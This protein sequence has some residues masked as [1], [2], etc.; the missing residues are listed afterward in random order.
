MNGPTEVKS[1]NIAWPAMGCAKAAAACRTSATNRAVV[2]FKGYNRRTNAAFHA[3][4]H[5][6]PRSKESSR[7]TIHRFVCCASTHDEEC[8]VLD[9]PRTSL[10]A[11]VRAGRRCV[12]GNCRRPQGGP[13]PKSD[14]VGGSCRS[15]RRPLMNIEDM[16]PFAATQE[17][18]WTLSADRKSVR[19]AV[20]ARSWLTPRWRPQQ[21]GQCR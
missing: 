12:Q 3:P 7:S 14:R 2:G 21:P 16:M 5:T 11:N 18:M 6:A 4:W 10:P 19:L 8:A 20:P 1:C 15:R 9:T 13:W 17:R